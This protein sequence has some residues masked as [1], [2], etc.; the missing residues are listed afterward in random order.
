MLKFIFILCLSLSAFAQEDVVQEPKQVVTSTPLDDFSQKAM[1][2]TSETISRE[3]LQTQGGGSLY[4]ALNKYPGIQAGSS[5]SG[6]TPFIRIRGNGS[7][8]R[9]LMLFDGIPLNTQDGL[10]GNPL[11]IPTELID[12]VDLIKGPSSLFYGSDAVGG[13]VNLK[14]KKLQ[15]PV[16]E[17]GLASN[18]EASLWLAAPMPKK[19]DRY[20]QISFFGLTNPGDYS[21]IDPSYGKTRRQHNKSQLQRYSLESYRNYGKT[22]VSFNVM[23]ATSQGQNPSSIPLNPSFENDYKRRGTLVGIDLQHHL[24]HNIDLLYKYNSVYSRYKEDS[25]GSRT[26][27]DSDKTIH[28]AMASFALSGNHQIDVLTDFSSDHYQTDYGSRLDKKNDHFEH[29]LIWRGQFEQ[30]SFVLA[31]TRFLPDQ[32]EFLKNILVKQVFPQHFIWASYSE[33]IRLPSFSQLYANDGFFIGNPNLKAE[34]SNQIEVGIERPMRNH[35]NQWYDYLRLKLSFYT[36][37]Y[38]NFI[39]YVPVPSPYSLENVE[40]VTS[41]GVEFLTSFDYAIYHGQLSYTLQSVQDKKAGKD[42]PLVP[43]SQAYLLLGAQLSTFVFEIQN[44]F[45]S[46]YKLDNTHKE[47]SW[48]TTDFSIRTAN[49]QKWSFRAGVQNIFDTQRNLAFGYP[50]PGRRYF[51]FAQ[52]E[53]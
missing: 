33:G 1:G 50:E 38:D 26:T 45:W 12:S 31:G 27:S 14:S 34:S 51:L 3:T 30:N 2:W 8:S 49:L 43:H 53:F 32:N 46:T 25:G 28:T 16:A 42:V 52:R 44:N 9:T 35:P 18:Q 6:N 21:Y 24:N 10:G 4:E 15:R 37:D 17:V 13:A 20:M 41:Q 22:E 29:G 23:Y 11:L 19:D 40:G 39:R 5:S 7:N 48:L 47:D 36:I